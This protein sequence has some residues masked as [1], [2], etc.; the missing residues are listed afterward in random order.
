MEGIVMDGRSGLTLEEPTCSL[1]QLMRGPTSSGLAQ[2][3][4]LETT[5]EGEINADYLRSLD[6]ETLTRM[7]SAS[8]TGAPAGFRD[9]EKLKWHQ[10]AFIVF[11]LMRFFQPKQAKPWGGIALFDA[12]GLGKTASTLGLHAILMGELDHQCSRRLGRVTPMLS[13]PFPAI[14]YAD[15]I[16]TQILSSWTRVVSIDGSYTGPPVLCRGCRHD[17]TPVGS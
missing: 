1:P 8:S 4:D 15:T 3:D 7:L 12:P 6:Q 9:E 16:M 13:M 5:M 14:F 11:A 17:Y 10:M 2:T